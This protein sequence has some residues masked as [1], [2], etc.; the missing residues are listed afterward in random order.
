MNECFDLFSF[1]Y[2][3]NIIVLNI[4]KTFKTNNNKNLW[5]GFASLLFYFFNVLQIDLS[6]FLFCF[7]GGF[8][9]I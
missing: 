7:C 2:N 6:Y 5:V 3:G 9:L 1:I 4:K 8:F